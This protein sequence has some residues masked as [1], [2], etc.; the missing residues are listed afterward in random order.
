MSLTFQT[1]RNCFSK[2]DL[3]PSLNV[4]NITIDFFS[5]WRLIQFITNGTISVVCL[6]RHKN[7]APGKLVK[8]NFKIGFCLLI[9]YHETKSKWSGAKRNAHT[10]LIKL[11]QRV[12]SMRQQDNLTYSFMLK[13]IQ[14]CG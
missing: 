9:R 1:V 10:L 12:T 11:T 7:R 6:G 4:T 3:I 14:I 13:E 5:K 8:L 2:S